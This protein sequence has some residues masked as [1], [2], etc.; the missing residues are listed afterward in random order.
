[1]KNT[2]MCAIAFYRKGDRMPWGYVAAAVVGGVASNS[3]AGKSADATKSASKSAT[4]LQR[5]QFNRGI[6]EV[7]PFKEA[8]LTA[9][10]GLTAAAND[11]ITPF[12]FQ[13]SGQYLNNYFNSP[14][15][16]ILNKQAQ[17]QIL[18]SNSATG[19]IRSGN[20]NA[21]L[22]MIAP[23]LGID[24]LRRTNQENLQAYGVNQG[25]IS[26]RYNRLY[27]LANMGANVASGNQSAGMNFASQ[28]GANAINAGNA[29]AQAYQKQGEAISGLAS[30]I[31]SIYAANKMGYFNNSNAGKI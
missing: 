5:E 4:A 26:D 8:G 10:P 1:M 18:R 20:T 27:G 24:S 9:L 11:P 31:G 23:T 16:N 3:A 29:Q 30:D 6:Q 21:D 25:A 22:A 13:D 17:D 19:G 28:A 12:A 14:E 2:H 7:A 15:Y